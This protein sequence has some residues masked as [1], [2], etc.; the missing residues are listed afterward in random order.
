MAELQT[1]SATIQDF[2][3]LW[4]L[5]CQ[6][7]KTY[8][9]ETWGWDEAWQTTQFRKHFPFKPSETEIIVHAGKDIG[10]I[11][12]QERDDEIF[13]DN[14]AILPSHQRRGCGT[15]LMKALMKKAADSK[16]PLRLNV[17]RVNPA[18]SLYERLG[19]HVT[20]SDD[21]KFHMEKALE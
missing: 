5:Y 2:D 3:F 1:R 21:Y 17:L 19:F 4:H 15:Q 20:G 14:V 13:L 11:C 10:Y 8:V 18:R 9:E 7:F 12:V 16:R 6:A